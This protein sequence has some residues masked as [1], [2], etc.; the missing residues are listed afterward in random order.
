MKRRET[1]AATTSM[2][3]RLSKAI[4]LHI[5]PQA[6]STLIITILDSVSLTCAHLYKKT[7]SVA[8]KFL[9]RI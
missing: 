2:K 4:Q 3:A 1:S 8:I 9:F 5:L 7:D 6:C